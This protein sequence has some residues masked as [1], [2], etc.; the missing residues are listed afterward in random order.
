MTSSRP[1]SRYAISGLP[2]EV[3]W[4]DVQ[5]VYPGQWAE[6]ER[7]ICAVQQ[8]RDAG[9]RPGIAAWMGY[10]P[11]TRTRV[12]PGDSPGILGC[13][14][15][16]WEWPA[17]DRGSKLKLPG[18]R[19]GNVVFGRSQYRTRHNPGFTRQINLYSGLRHGGPSVSYCP[20][21]RR[22]NRSPVPLRSGDHSGP[23]SAQ[24]TVMGHQYY[25]EE[26]AGTAGMITGRSTWRP[27][28]VAQGDPHVG[29]YDPLWDRAARCGQMHRNTWWQRLS[30][31]PVVRDRGWPRGMP[32]TTDCQSGWARPCWPV[33]WKKTLPP[34]GKR[35]RCGQNGSSGNEPK[36]MRLPVSAWDI[37]CKPHCWTEDPCLHHLVCNKHRRRDPSC[38]SHQI[39][40]RVGSCT[41]RIWHGQA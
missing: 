13:V 18:I 29:Q 27:A 11:W 40:A 21:T 4:V 14:R 35:L 23:C 41:T 9:S 26:M 25:M 2:V 3:H 10:L 24:R 8:C 39:V 1:Q 7:P 19:C 15:T 22:V 33:S 6:A 32:G 30:S 12:C 31:P 20:C 5:L 37:L 36:G 17:P 16:L 28:T 34:I 38:L